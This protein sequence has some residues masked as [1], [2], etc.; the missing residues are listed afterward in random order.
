MIALAERER[1]RRW[2]D[3]ACLAGARQGPACR[4]L[5]LS[6]RTLQRWA[7]G[8]AAQGDGRL[9]RRGRGALNAL[10]AAERA[11]VLA[12]ANSTEFA[13][14]PPSQI[15][16]RLAERGCYVASEST[17][18]RMSVFTHMEPFRF[19]LNGARVFAL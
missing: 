16:P 14:L 12:I 2:I 8:R 13:D 4:L 18:Y 15:V 3:E 10:S 6:E 9:C 17:F 1:I 7:K 11:T 19:H 5:G